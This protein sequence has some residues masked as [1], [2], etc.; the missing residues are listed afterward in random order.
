M[1]R[2]K[3]PH[4]YL[5]FFSM[6]LISKGR[7]LILEAWRFSFS[8]EFENCRKRGKVMNVIIAMTIDV[9]RFSV[10]AH[11][12]WSSTVLD[13]LENFFD[14]FLKTVGTE[15]SIFVTLLFR[16]SIY[17]IQRE[18]EIEPWNWRIFALMLKINSWT[19]NSFSIMVLT[20]I[21]WVCLALSFQAQQFQFDLAPIN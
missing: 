13:A 17:S 15:T 8:A 16:N 5:R 1:N 11:P 20:F 4:S 14:V 19:F 2:R 9:N 18:R 7:K 12:C 6:F 3:V 21:K 10:T